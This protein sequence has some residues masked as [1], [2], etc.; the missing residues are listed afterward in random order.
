MLLVGAK[1]HL[2]ASKNCIKRPEQPRTY[3]KPAAAPT[4]TQLTPDDQLEDGGAMP[5]DTGSDTPTWREVEQ[6]T[7]AINP[8]AESMDSRG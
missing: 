7:V 4:V 2:M 8:S 5:R 1:V 3:D 6:D